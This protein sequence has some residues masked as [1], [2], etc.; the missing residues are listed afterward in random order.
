MV[1][2]CVVMLLIGRF[3]GFSGTILRVSILVA[4]SF[5]CDHRKLTRIDQILSSHMAGPNVAAIVANNS[6]FSHQ[7]FNGLAY[8]SHKRDFA[9][10]FSVQAPVVSGDHN[11]ETRTQL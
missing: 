11:T 4:L 8:C 3:A 10:P 1:C 7:I 2:V 5:Q 9:Q 6:R